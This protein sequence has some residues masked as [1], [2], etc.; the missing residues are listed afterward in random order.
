MDK[1]R[2]LVIDDSEAI[3]KDFQRILCPEPLQEWDELARLEDAL[4]GAPEESQSPS[5]TEF[6]MDSAFQ[7]EEGFDKV[8]EAEAAGRPYALVFLDYRMPPGWDGLETLRHL[9]TVAPALPVVLCSAY[10]DYQWT[11]IM[12]ELGGAD[13]LKE[14]RKP[15]DKHELHQL[16]LALSMPQL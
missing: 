15:F 1:K 6:E 9:R 14:L 12:Q 8:R 16:A 11:E 13:P 10:S 3:H 7:G 4:F 2:I 5:G